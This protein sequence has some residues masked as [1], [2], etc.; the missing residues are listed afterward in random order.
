M[1]D[2]YFAS[3]QAAKALFNMGLRFIGTVKTATKGFPMH[4]LQRV[5]LPGGK[6]DHKALLARDE[7]GMNMI[8]MVWADRDRRYFIA[9][10]SSTSPGNTIQR[11]RWRQR[12]LAPNVDA[13]VEHVRIQQTELGEMFYD[14]CQAID[15]HNRSRQEL[16]NLEKKVQTMSWSNR[17]N[18]SILG[19]CMVDC[20]NLAKGC[21]GRINHLGGARQFFEDLLTDLIDNDFDRRT[22]RRRREESVAKEA[23]LTGENMPELDTSRHL[24]APTPTKRRKTKNPKHRAQGCCMICKTGLTSHVCRACQCFKTAS[25]DKQFWICNKP[26]CTN[27]NWWIVNL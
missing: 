7:T 22:L 14:G 17:A 3:V 26:G 2:S 11:R 8:A 18:H 20:Y 24:T 19:M 13:E 9:T 23:A 25:N 21:Q 15:K 12:D 27:R 6:G 10:C 4:F 16:L 5:L 1:A